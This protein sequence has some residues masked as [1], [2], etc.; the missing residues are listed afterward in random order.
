M[1]GACGILRDEG[2]GIVRKMIKRSH[3]GASAETQ[4]D[5]QEMACEICHKNNFQAI[6]VPQV[7]ELEK[8]SYT[9]DRIDDSYSYESKESCENIDFVRELRVFFKEFIDLG[10]VPADF[11]CYK[12]KDGRISIVDFDKFIKIGQNGEMNFFGRN[13]TVDDMLKGSHIPANF[14]LCE[15]P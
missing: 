6:F 14:S 13:V 8:R 15:S 2:D 1:E 11:E 5:L 10:Y 12:Q 3:R 9:M 7:Y 4:F